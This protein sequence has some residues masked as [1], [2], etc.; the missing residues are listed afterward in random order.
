VT[1]NQVLKAVKALTGASDARVNRKVTAD[2]WSLELAFKD[3]PTAYTFQTRLVDVSGDVV[4][5]VGFN[6]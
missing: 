1:D 5:M 4:R 2:T 6:F 3:G